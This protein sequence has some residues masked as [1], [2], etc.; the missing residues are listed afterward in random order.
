MNV[1]P[2]DNVMVSP[3]DDIADAAWDDDAWEDD[4]DDPLPFY[5]WRYT[6]RE[7]LPDGTEVYDERPLTYDDLLNPQEEDHMVHSSLHQRCYRYLLNVLAYLYKDDP[8]TLVLDD[9]LI[10]WGIAGLPKHAPD[11]A[12][13]FDVLEQREE[14]TTFRVAEQGTR[15]ALLIEICSYGTRRIDL[16]MKVEHYARAGVPWYAIVDIQRRKKTGIRLRL[17]GYR[18]TEAGVYAPV[19]LDKQG[20]LWLDPVGIW[21]GTREGELLCYDADGN[22]LYDYPD[23]AAE[24]EAVIAENQTIKAEHEAVIAE[25]QTTRDENQSLQAE[26]DRLRAELARLTQAGDGQ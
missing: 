26:V 13:I 11:I 4:E 5:G 25:N 23:M 19:S 7:V 9:S 16:Q 15:P 10:D 3:A 2:H 20:R 8:T 12:V 1:P 22:E 21:L 6:L 14:W 17:L 24:H 18:L